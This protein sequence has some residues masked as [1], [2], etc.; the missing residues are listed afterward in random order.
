MYKATAAV[1][2]T[3]GADFRI[4][5]GAWAPIPDKVTLTAARVAL[6]VKQA[7]AVLINP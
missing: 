1:S 4:D 2:A 5:G 3:V 6:S 7:R